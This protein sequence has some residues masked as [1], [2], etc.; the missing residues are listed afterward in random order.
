MTTRVANNQEQLNL[1]APTTIAGLHLLRYCWVIKLQRFVLIEDPFNENYQY[2]EPQ[3]NDEFVGVALPQVRNRRMKP[4][5]F[6]KERHR[7]YNVVSRVDLRPDKSDRIIYEADSGTTVL[8]LHR[9]IRI[10][11][12]IELPK[13]D[14]YLNHLRKILNEDDE[15]IEHVLKWSAHLLFKP[16]IRMNHGILISGVEVGTGKSTIAYVLGKLLKQT[17]HVVKP[18]EI[19]GRFTDWAL[20]KRLICVEEV[21]QNKSHDWFN[22]IKIYFTG[23]MVRIELKN[24]SLFNIRNNLHFMMFSNRANPIALDRSDRRLFYLHSHVPKPDREEST[25]YFDEL[26]SYLDN[27]YGCWS[28]AKYL[29]D[30]YLPKIEKGFAYTAPIQTKDHHELLIASRTKL[31]EKLASEFERPTRSKHKLFKKEKFFLFSDLKQYLDDEYKLPILANNGKT[32]SI[33]KEL[34]LVREYHV[35]DG[36]RQEFSWWSF[37]H[38]FCK[39]WW[40]E[41]SKQKRAYFKTCQAQYIKKELRG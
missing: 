22:N 12:N 40:K 2:T 18:N 3:F 7:E 14:L 1:N 10:P 17:Y 19:V 5:E 9:P 32:N 38:K 23:E 36:V 11:E 21:E 33:L 15:A 20:N 24:Q 4:S 35:L 28:F 37:N 34:G 31:E 16:E 8:N 13:P 39:S 6:I 26:Y 41:T 29:R 25:R 30:V 27:Q